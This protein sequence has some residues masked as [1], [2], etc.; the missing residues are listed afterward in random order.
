MS[1]L[2]RATRSAPRKDYLDISENGLPTT[3]IRKSN[4]NSDANARPTNAVNEAIDRLRSPVFDINEAVENLIDEAV[5]NP[6]NE[7]VDNSSNLNTANT[8]LSFSMSDFERIYDD[9]TPF[10]PIRRP[11]STTVQDRSWVF[12]YFTTTVLDNQFYTPNGSNTQRNDRI[13]RCN[14]CNWSVL[15]SKRGGSTSNLARHLAQH[16]ISKKRSP[17]S[18]PTVLDLLNN[19]STKPLISREQSVIDWVVDG[20]YPFVAVEYRPFQ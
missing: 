17:N 9:G 14:R 12:Q 2:D 16:K 6:F 19:V 7:T 18:N 1:T 8:P 20:L 5:L 10:E 4:I 3:P 11:K 15:D 13:A